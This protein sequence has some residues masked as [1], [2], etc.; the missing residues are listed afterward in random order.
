M[1]SIADLSEH[2]RCS[3]ATVSNVLRANRL[4]YVSIQRNKK[5]YRRV[6]ALQL[7]EAYFQ[8]PKSKFKEKP[9]QARVIV[10]DLDRVKMFH[11]N[12]AK[13]SKERQKYGK[14]RT[15]V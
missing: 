6:E 4:S 13:L 12:M 2:F 15:S 10:P 7:L 9:L 3:D 1:M 14:A 8:K 5:L 11:A